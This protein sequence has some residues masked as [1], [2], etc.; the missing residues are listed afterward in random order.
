MTKTF[1]T[2]IMLS[3]LILIFFLG[4]KQKEKE[5]IEVKQVTPVTVC[6]IG[7]EE[8]SD[9]LELNAVSSYLKKNSVRATIAGTIDQVEL[10]IGD[11]V[12]K[13]QL[14]YT[15]KTKEAAALSIKS[16]NADTSFNFKGIIKIISP[17]TGIISSITHQRG[18]YVQEGDELAV[19]AEQSSLVFLMQVPFEMKSYIKA[20]QSCKVILPDNNTLNA[21]VQSNLPVMD[22][23]S[24][25]QNIVVKC[26][27]NTVIPENLLAMVRILK[28]FKKQTIT[29]P[30][31]CILTNETQ[32]L[33]WVMKLINDTTAVKVPVKKGIEAKDKIEVTEPL[34]NANDRII[35]TGNYGLE[36]TAK[37]T[38]IKK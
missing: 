25:T 21:S 14:L 12:E 5:D 31:E 22:I 13:G 29:L 1:K 28:D 10:N 2:Y 36:D 24:Q 8:M 35:F 7:N 30:K 26:E 20:R 19:V 38:I 33:F 27:T 6:S 3:T 37:V 9:Y 15:I 4:C 32:N 18:D 16:I 34:F 11:K 17:K 23:A